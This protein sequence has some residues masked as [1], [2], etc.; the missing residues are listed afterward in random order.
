L[1]GKANR[2]TVFGLNLNNLME[3]EA[4]KE[5]ENWTIEELRDN[6]AIQFK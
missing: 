2:L 6:S 3:G 4:A 1:L 5:K